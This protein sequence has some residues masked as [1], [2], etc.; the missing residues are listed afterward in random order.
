MTAI[1]V[2][3]EI[4]CLDIMKELKAAG[5][6]LTIVNNGGMSCLMSAS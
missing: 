6:D 2:A 5:A 3:C 4:G 1:Y